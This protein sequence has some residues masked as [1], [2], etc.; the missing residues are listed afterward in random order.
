MLAALS[1]RAAARG[2]ELPEDTASFLLKRIPRDPSSV[3]NLLDRL[4]EASMVERRRLTIPFVKSVLA[5]LTA[6][7]P[8]SDPSA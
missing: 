5:N 1:C 2:L 6:G 8:A 4:D 7:S 3:F